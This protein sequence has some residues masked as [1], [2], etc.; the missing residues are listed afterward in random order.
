MEPCKTIIVTLGPPLTHPWWWDQVANT[1]SRHDVRHLRISVGH[2]TAPQIGILQVPQVALQLWRLLRQGERDGNTYICTFESDL[3]CYL[4]G[5]LQRLPGCRRPRH[6]ILQFITRKVESNLASRAKCVVSKLLLHSVWLVVCSSKSEAHYYRHTFDWAPSK[7][8]YVPL[9]T[10]QR[11]L[12]YRTDESNPPYIVATGRSYRDYG[13]LARAVAGTGISTRIVCGRQGSGIRITPSEIHV[14]Q[15]LP[16]DE[17]MAR[18]ANSRFMVL[19]L[20]LQPIS[21]GQTV[22]LQA[23]ALGKAVIA[24]KTAGTTDYIEDGSNGILVTP[25]DADGLR[26]A[27][28]EL[29]SNDALRARLGAAA[30]E[31]VLAK[32][33]PDHYASNLAVILRQPFES[34]RL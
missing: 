1:R 12:D 10:D 5:L 34:N 19:P 3:S 21:T 8:A 2:R 14:E 27:I 31:T 4:I 15:E 26:T 23:M 11:I 32:H 28:M 30:R 9:H 17:F 33:L 18:I 20:E 16:I 25:D 22:L 13:T 6:V 7:I 24:T 29:W